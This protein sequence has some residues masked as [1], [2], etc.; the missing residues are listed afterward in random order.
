MGDA[1]AAAVLTMKERHGI[2]EARLLYQ[3]LLKLPP[4]GGSFMH[5]VIDMESA[6][7]QSPNGL[8]HDQLEQVF[9][10]CPSTLL[11]GMHA[12]L[13]FCLMSMLCLGSSSR[14]C[15]PFCGC[16]LCLFMSC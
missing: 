14:T 1:A 3:K 2:H 8:K 6:L 5:A 15:S 7:L 4:V 11:A 9:E 16:R 10:V 12:H 13:P